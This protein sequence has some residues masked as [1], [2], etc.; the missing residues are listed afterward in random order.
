MEDGSLRQTVQLDWI[1]V[2][3]AFSSGFDQNLIFQQPLCPQVELPAGSYTYV[4]P[5]G[6]PSTK[7]SHCQLEAHINWRDLVRPHGAYK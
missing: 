3:C 1:A 6:P 5:N 7:A 2:S 4:D